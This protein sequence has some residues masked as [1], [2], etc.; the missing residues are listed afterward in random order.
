[1][2]D[3]NLN[4]AEHPHETLIAAYAIGKCSLEVQTEIDEHCFTCE[5]AEHPGDAREHAEFVFDKD[6]NGVAHGERARS[7]GG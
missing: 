4:L 5:P 6:G 1:M 3:K 2:K 7:L